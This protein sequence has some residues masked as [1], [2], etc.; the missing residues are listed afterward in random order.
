LG[1]FGTQ[2]FQVCFS[3]ALARLLTPAEF[4]AIGMLFV[5]T[6]FAQVLSDSGL[7]SA[8]IYNQKITEAHRSTAFW[9]QMAIGACLTLLFYFIAPAI[10]RF[11]DL[12]ILDPLT[13]LISVVFVMQALGQTQSALLTKEF[14]FRRLAIATTGATVISG[15]VALVMARFGFGIWALAWQILILSGMSTVSYWLLSNW[16]PH[17]LFDRAAAEE[18]GKYSGYLLG[19]GS[20]NYWV[21]NGDNL[22]VGK[23]LGAH[24]LGIY[25]RGYSLMLL[26]LNNISAVLGQVMFPA[27][28]QVQEDIPRFRRTFLTAI[29]LIA[30]IS[31]PLMIGLA[32]LAD[33]F[34]KVLLGLRWVEVV[35]VLHVLSLV[36]LAQ[37]IIAPVG[38]IYTGLGKTRAQFQV[39][40]FLAIAF[41]VA[42]AVGLRHGVMGVVYAYAAWA[43]FSG[44]STYYVA[45]RYIHLSVFTILR[46]VARI[47]VMTFAMGA[48]VLLFNVGMAHAWSDAAR[49][50]GGTVLGIAAYLVL[51]L[52][53]RDETFDEL[54]RFT[55]V[56]KIA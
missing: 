12:Q 16:R 30:L 1:R 32:V 7:S 19:F 26:P 43:V 45:G 18:M 13:R 39:S 55:G 41:V 25:S 29:R 21:R 5:F 53:T 34:I 11:Y 27:L 28:S 20:F 36:G 42:M 52:V 3:I 50:G 49:L 47:S 2:L 15:G 10:A 4:G 48:I 24:P 38:W 17:F 6:G 9:L 40:I 23:F 56:R 54:L 51:C 31:F 44:V 35:P 37:S 14:Q 33:P 46:S 22:A 8:L